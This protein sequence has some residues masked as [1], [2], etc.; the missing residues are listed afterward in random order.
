MRYP[1]RLFWSNF[2]D[3]LFPR[4][5]EACHRSLEGN[6]DVICTACLA[7][8][9]RVSDQSFLRKALSD[10]FIHYPQV[11]SVTSFLVFSKKGRVQTLLHTLKYKGGEDIG[12]KLGLLSGAELAER[13]EAPAADLITTVPLHARRKKAR[14]YNQC[15]SFA[16]GLSEALG[17]PWSGDLIRRVRH[18]ASQTG[19][20]RGE[21]RENVRGSFQIHRASADFPRRI[22]L[23]DDVMTT[24]ATLEAC[25]E[26]LL[27]AGAPYPEIHIITIAAARY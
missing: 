1:F 2:I 23:I 17:I 3:L 26:A 24:G 15:D 18:T 11:R 4:C 19:K 13:Q 12:K 14:G 27:G 9:P 21:R 16:A 5:C 8:L 10:K 25:V 7:E 20:S 6:E 22:I